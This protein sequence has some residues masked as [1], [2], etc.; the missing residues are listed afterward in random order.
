[1]LVPVVARL[2]AT[3]LDREVAPRLGS[4]TRLTLRSATRLS[5]RFVF[6][7]VLL[8]AAPFRALAQ[9]GNVG[10]GPSID[11]PPAPTPPETINRGEDGKITMRAVRVDQ[12]LDL[13]GAL[14]E[15]VYQSVP[16]ASHF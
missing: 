16:S 15:P 8:C 7:F 3:W 13:D 1:M 5:K 6:V 9:V 10:G 14:E 4:N 2:C 11:G 12:P